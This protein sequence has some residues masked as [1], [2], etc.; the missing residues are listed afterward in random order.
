MRYLTL[1]HLYAY[2]RPLATEGPTDEALRLIIEDAERIVESDLRSFGYEVPV[3][4]EEALPQMRRLVLYR[5]LADV[6]ASPRN[7]VGGPEMAN[8]WEARY[9]LE[10]AEV[11][12][13]PDRLPGV[14]KR[15][16]HLP[17]TVNLPRP[18]RPSLVER[19]R[20]WLPQ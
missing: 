9:R 6:L 12:N 5:V 19:V 4:S 3:T 14:P 8:Y 16:A 13:R 11:A 20:R 15:P 10:L 7:Q 18:P 2:Y 17:Q 1:E